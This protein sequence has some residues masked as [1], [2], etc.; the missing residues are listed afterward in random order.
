MYFLETVPKFII[1]SLEIAKGYIAFDSI[2]FDI[3]EINVMN[4][5]FKTAFL[6]Q[7]LTFLVQ[8]LTSL[9]CYFMIPM[10]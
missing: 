10:H 2:Y 6:V 9:K 7:V 4:E 8:V 1:P 3:R 5:R